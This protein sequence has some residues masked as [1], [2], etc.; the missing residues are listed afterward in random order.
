[1]ITVMVK[2]NSVFQ[3]LYLL[4]ESLDQEK[5]TQ[6]LVNQVMEGYYQED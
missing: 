2:L 3:V 1:M 5:L 6:W 4:M